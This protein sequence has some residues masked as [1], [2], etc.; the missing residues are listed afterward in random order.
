ML[1]PTLRFDAQNQLEGV[2]ESARQGNHPEGDRTSQKARNRHAPLA[3]L[4]NTCSIEGLNTCSSNQEE[5]V[6][7]CLL[8]KERGLPQ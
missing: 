4:H 6:P 3:A 7:C 8:L 2:R 1:M 5:A